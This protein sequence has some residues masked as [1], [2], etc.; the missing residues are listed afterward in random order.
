MKGTVKGR[1]DKMKFKPYKCVKGFG[2]RDGKEK[3]IIV[4]VDPGKSGGYA[5][6]IDGKL[7][8]V[9]PFKKDI[10]RVRHLFTAFSVPFLDVH[11]FIEQVTASPQMGVVSAFTF[12]K[13]AEAPIT[14]AYCSGKPYY[15]VRPQVWQS[16]IGCFA[17]GDKKVLYEHAKRLYPCEHGRKMF[18]KDTADSV[19]I[20]H[21]GWKRVTGRLELPS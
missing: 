4:G 18:N 20:A 2:Y 13:W 19:L 1:G 6:I 3:T 5:V 12:G 10:E 9:W 16:A 7:D 11:I 8:G 15:M 14:S 17:Q 21:Y